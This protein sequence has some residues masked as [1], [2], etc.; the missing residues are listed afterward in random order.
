VDE[1]KGFVE[2]FISQYNGFA[3][4]AAEA[5]PST[6]TKMPTELQDFGEDLGRL[7]DA[8]QRELMGELI[9]S[10]QNTLDQLD[11]VVHG[12][13]R[14]ARR[15]TGGT[16]QAQLVEQATDAIHE[17][18]NAPA[19][20]YQA[21]NALREQMHTLKKAVQDTTNPQELAELWKRAIDYKGRK[22]SLAN[23]YPDMDLSTLTPQTF[24]KRMWTAFFET[25]AEV[26]RNGNNDIYA[27]S[28]DAIENLA[29]SLGT[30]IEEMAGRP[31]GDNPFRVLAKMYKQS[32]DIEDAVSWR[33]FL[34][35]FNFEKMPVKPDG[36]P[37]MLSDVAGKFQDVFKSWK[38]GQ[39]HIVN[40]VAKDTGKA[41]PYEQIT[42]EQAYRAIWKR[43]RVP[44]DDGT[45][46]DARILWETKDEF[47]ADVER[48]SERVVN[49]WGVKVKTSRVDSTEQLRK[50]TSA[51]NERMGS[52]RTAAG[53]VAVETR[54]F[55]LHDYDKTYLDHA[56]T[57]LFGNSFHYWTTRTYAKS[58]ETLMSNPAVGANYMKYKDYMTKEH[59]N[60]PEFYRQNVVIQNLLGIDMAS[61]YYLN[62]E[63]M[64]NPVYGLTGT[65]FNDPRKRV[66]WVSRLVDDS[67]KMGASFSPLVQWALAA[68]L[69]MDGE[70]G[71]AQRWLGRLLPQS[72]VIKSTTAALTGKAIEIDPFVQLTNQKFLGGVD[73]YERNRVVAALAMMVRDGEIT[74]EQMID[75]AN[76][77]EGELWEAAVNISAQNRFTGDIASYFIGVGARPRT[78]EDMI[79]NK[80]WGDYSTLLN[81][82]SMMTADQYRTAWENLRENPEYGMFVDGLLLGRKTGE[83]Q[84]TA[85]AYNVL[86]RI[87]PGEL[88]DIAEYVGMEA[89]MIEAFYENK[90][91]I[92]SLTA[93]DQAR[94]KAAIADLSAILKMPDGA[95]RQE[96]AL[97]KS[98]YADMNTRL[99]DEFGADIQ[100]KISRFY[101]LRDDERD[102][103]L[104][105][106]PEVEQALQRQNQYIVETP[107]LSA[108]YGGLS[109]VERYYSN[110]MYNQLEDEFGADIQDKMEQYYLL[111]D[112]LQTSEAKAFYKTNNLKAYE[113][114]K[115][116]LQAIADEM[117]VNAVKNLPERREY[118]VRPEFQPQGGIQEQTYEYA[119]VDEQA[120][121]AQS[122]WDELSPAAQTLLQESYETD[123]V[124]PSEVKRMVGYIAERYGLTQAEALRLL[125][126]EQ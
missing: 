126:I 67:G 91:D 83:A 34:N 87:P 59:A 20:Q 37:V 78:Q 116:E 41:I 90:G 56:L 79:I 81:S 122:I 86:S 85:L 31:G 29:K 118:E 36:S 44:P 70:E 27:K 75:A 115:K 103:Y 40:A 52:V 39:K 21:I 113:K 23:I 102:L 65:D 50:F 43:T 30:T 66:D 84:T 19:S 95:T 46:N 2:E 15:N 99:K 55:V 111:K 33:R 108:Y 92:S 114:R 120:Q 125:E 42:L 60:M 32:E 64:I 105:A 18:A 117:I 104:D 76:S 77:E 96:W 51:F 8:G 97:A 101:D 35:Q 48:W 1:F 110:Q 61:P 124:V 88:S 107:I 71:A 4:R 49:D 58:I 17:L 28:L 98:T 121:I 3:T 53:R 119:T 69:Y 22:F 93:Q 106:Y 123:E 54:N 5:L 6:V 72:S 47:L 14:Q 11:E 63:A 62:L 9:Q 7:S 26:Y 25:S 68:K 12:V 94:F 13:L 10:W 45:I 100:D 112:N 24:Q 89:Y 80:F 73:A 16:P 74:E 38:G 57:Y 109:A 82:R